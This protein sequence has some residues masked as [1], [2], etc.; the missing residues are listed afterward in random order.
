MGNCYKSNASEEQISYDKNVVIYIRQESLVSKFMPADKVKFKITNPV[1]ELS[2][3]LL[4]GSYKM[5]TTGCIIPGQDPRGEVPKKCQDHFFISSKP[6][7]LFI[8]LFDGHGSKGEEIVR[9][10]HKFIEEKFL[11][12]NISLTKC[13]LFLTELFESCDVAIKSQGGKINA[14]GS[15][16]TA[17]CLLFVNDGI[18]VASVGDSRAILATI[19][20]VQHIPIKT[21]SKNPY[22]KIFTPSR[23]LEPIQLTID[24]KPNLETELN[25]ILA[26][27]GI[28]AKAKDEYGESYGPYRVFQKGKQ[29][30]GLAMSR[31]L[32]DMSAKKV[33]VISTPIIDFYPIISFKD[34]FI[35]VASD[36]VWDA[37]D[38]NEVSNFV[39]TFRRKC[40]KEPK[41][42]DDENTINPGNSTIARLLVEEARYRWFGICSEEDAMID[43]ISALVIEIHTQELTEHDRGTRTCSRFSKFTSSYLEVDTS[44]ISSVHHNLA[45]ETII[46]SEMLDETR[47]ELD[48]DVNDN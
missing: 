18:Y 30:P 42:I 21:K 14:L 46:S 23:V 27:G 26:A 48:E 12:D 4:I 7:Y 1:N 20:E 17:I 40:L 35:V 41:N 15:G 9:F 38:N 36:G 28:V 6:E 33:G 32:G 31:S 10:A 8:T 43:D 13:D 22:K 16:T 24:Q 47:V 5:I 11:I 34:Q 25:R 2:E 19:P 3:N 44:N 37:M 29:I 45:R 39:E